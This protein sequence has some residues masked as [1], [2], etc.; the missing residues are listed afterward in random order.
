M[1]N[2]DGDRAW[3]DRFLPTIKQIVGPYLMVESPDEVD[4]K[5]A[6]DLII[7]RA[8]DM[9][10][11]CRVRRSGFADKYG[12]EFTIRSKR[13]NGCTT[14]ITKIVDGFGDW[15]FYGHAVDNSS[16]AIEPWFLIDLAAFRAHLVRD[17]RL[18]KDGNPVPLTYREDIA[19]GDGTF[20][21]A[22]DVDS[23]QGSP[24][25]LIAEHRV[26]HDGVTP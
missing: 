7:L 16:T 9:M 2:Y 22:F 17:S 1:G 11:A 18:L 5:Q 13:S 26:H 15:M 6:S 24:K 20:F 4:Q 12:R 19:N 14:E 3:S 21:T 23:F 10:V 25:L 8:R